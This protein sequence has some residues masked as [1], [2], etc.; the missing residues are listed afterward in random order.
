[1]KESLH[2]SCDGS[3]ITGIIMLEDL[4]TADIEDSE[5]EGINSFVEQYEEMQIGVTIRELPD[6]RSRCSTRTSG[7]ISANEIC[8]RHGG[9]GH[10]H[11]AVCELDERPEE[12]RMIIEK[13]CRNYL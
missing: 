6:G 11:A 10:F 8:A 13:T 12:A 4:K 5:L 3:L 1:M 7:H 2:F 9:G